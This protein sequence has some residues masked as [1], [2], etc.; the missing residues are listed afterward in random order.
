MRA[1]PKEKIGHGLW[2]TLQGQ[3]R[4]HCMAQPRQSQEGQRVAELWMQTQGKAL[5]DL[6][7]VWATKHLFQYGVAWVGGCL[8][9]QHGLSRDLHLP[10]RRSRWAARLQ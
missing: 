6:E 10:Y 1:R 3:P 4:H 7:K 9:I 5:A 2:G 8:N